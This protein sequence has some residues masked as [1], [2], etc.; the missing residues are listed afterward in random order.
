MR[1]EGTEKMG[2]KDNEWIEREREQVGKMGRY[3]EIGLGIGMQCGRENV[4]CVWG[5]GIERGTQVNTLR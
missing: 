5:G 4:G 2:E 1:K 3:C